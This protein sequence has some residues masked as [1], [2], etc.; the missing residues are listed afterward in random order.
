[1]CNGGGYRLNIESLLDLEVLAGKLLSINC[2]VT[3]G[4]FSVW[5]GW[6]N[7]DLQ[8]PCG[9]GTDKL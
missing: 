2:K 4:V 3:Q 5:G 9:V 6:C 1:M 7:P 8:S